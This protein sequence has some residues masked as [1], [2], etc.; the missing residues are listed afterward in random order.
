MRVIH[1]MPDGVQNNCCEGAVDRGECKS[2]FLMDLDQKV[3]WM[4]GVSELADRVDQTN[5]LSYSS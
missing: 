2:H 1:D 3:E 4:R 5:P